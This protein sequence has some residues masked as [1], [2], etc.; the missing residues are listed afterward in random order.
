MEDSTAQHS[1]AQQRFINSFQN[2]SDS[3]SFASLL[4][5]YNTV[6]E[7]RNAKGSFCCLTRFRNMDPTKRREC[8][9]SDFN[10][11]GNFIN[12][13]KR[14]AS[15]VLF[16]VPGEEEPFFSLIFPRACISNVGF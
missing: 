14:I 3:D 2:S 13:F 15:S 9:S 5:C 6:S 8:K 11:N 12:F 7:V 4:C 10:V 1:T 16:S